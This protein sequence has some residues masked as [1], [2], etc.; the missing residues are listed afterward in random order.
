MS[1]GVVR[2]RK[3][4]KVEGATKRQGVY[5]FHF[6]DK[7]QFSR[8][9]TARELAVVNTVVHTV[10]RVTCMA[11]PQTCPDIV[12]GVSHGTHSAML[13]VQ[14]G[15]GVFTHIVSRLVFSHCARSQTV[16][17]ENRKEEIEACIAEVPHTN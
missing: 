14:S 10:A 3:R 1:A 15:E 12:C 11:H 2:F 6:S 17:C 16:L 9:C 8:S 13:P 7:C 5:G 4:K